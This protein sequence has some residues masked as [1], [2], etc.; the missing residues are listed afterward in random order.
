MTPESLIAAFGYVALFAGTVLEGETFVIIAVILA[1]KG[2]LDMHW[3]LAVAFSGA[4]AGDQSCFFLGRKHGERFLRNRPRW[5]DRSRL[6]GECVARWETPVLMGYRFC[7]GLRAVTPFVVGMNG[8]SIRRFVAL[9][10]MGTALWLA[11]L[12]S[13]GIVFGRLVLSVLADFRQTG[14]WLLVGA[15]IIAVVAW[16]WRLGSKRGAS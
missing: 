4:V 16:G 6:V 1:Q 9:S 15:M 2:A 11:V 12:S 7:Y 13:A 3:V 14:Q 5:R 8:F 10:L